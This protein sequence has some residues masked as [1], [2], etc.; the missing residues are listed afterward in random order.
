MTNEYIIK[1]QKLI[2]EIK[3]SSFSKPFKRPPIE[4]LRDKN[5][6]IQ[7]NE[8]IKKPM[9]LDLVS[10]KLR[11]NE[12]CNIKE[13][14]DDMFL[15]FNNA[16]LF[17]RD[18]SKIYEFAKSL[19]IKAQLRFEEMKFLP[20][21]GIVRNLNIKRKKSKNEHFENDIYL[22]KKKKN[23]INYNFDKKNIKKCFK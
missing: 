23:R 21:S 12:Y 1:F 17:N 13:F 3:K 14:I 20:E 18:G 15:I 7:Y 4:T 10:Y 8:I 22:N 6:K 19:K 5:L 11:N 9:Y 2:S 16:M